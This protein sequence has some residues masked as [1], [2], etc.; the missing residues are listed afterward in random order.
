MK[1]T[2]Y[3]L[4]LT[5]FFCDAQ[6]Q[7]LQVKFQDWSVFKAKRGDSV[8]CYVASTPI[9]RE[10]NY[11]K[12]GE[13]YFLVTEI[14]ND[15][16]E[17]SVSSGF[18]YKQKSDVELSFGSKKYHLFPY[19]SVAWANNKN[20][21]IDIIKEMQRVEEFVVTGVTR[22][23]KIASDTYSLIGFSQ[24]YKKMKENCLETI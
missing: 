21:D 19:L 23:G 10:G 22:E 9:K 7:E 18:I 5:L 3:C 15:A 24:A 20:D 2:K 4:F 1:F 8:V 13:P 11:D 17:I 16:D 12:R 14:I 6:A